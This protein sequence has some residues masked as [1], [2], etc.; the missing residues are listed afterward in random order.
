MAQIHVHALIP[1]LG[2]NLEEPVAI[3]I[4]GVVD[5][6]ANRTKVFFRFLDRGTQG[7]DVGQISM[8][9]DGTMR[10]VAGESID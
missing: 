8:Q 10:G 7:G 4:R 1:I 6:N 9:V 5:E 3:V 2:C